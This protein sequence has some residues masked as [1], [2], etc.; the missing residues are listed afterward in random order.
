MKRRDRDTWDE[1]EFN[2]LLDQHHGAVRR[3]ARRRLSDPA[4][5]DDVLAETF[6]VAWRRRDAIP[7]ESPIAWLIGV[8]SNVIQTH[9]RGAR[10]RHR[11]RDRL[12]S[13]REPHGNDPA[14][15]LD[16]KD[17]VQ[18]AF[19]ALTD[20]QREVLRLVAWDDLSIAEAAE[21][22]GCTPGAFRVR[23][24]RARQELA[25]QLDRSGHRSFEADH[26][27]SDD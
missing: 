9:E 13:L 8:C 1:D 12:S 7:Q 27:R 25:K 21:I 15:L 17:P 26:E 11:L 14:E 3:F 4:A 5:I 2:R 23:V 22:S 10:R 24:H 6:L 20:G 16:R 18:R 19:E